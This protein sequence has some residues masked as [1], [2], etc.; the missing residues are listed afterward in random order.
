MGR[1]ADQTNATH[2]QS[3]MTNGD[4]HGTVRGRHH[5]L[6]QKQKTFDDWNLLIG[7]EEMGSDHR[8]AGE[9]CLGKETTQRQEHS[10]DHGRQCR[11]NS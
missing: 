10:T 11:R 8:D 3:S 4:C 6:H 9:G 2:D 1:T 5:G 7:H